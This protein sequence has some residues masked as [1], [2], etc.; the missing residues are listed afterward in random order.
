MDFPGNSHTSRIEQQEDPEETSGETKAASEAKQVKKV[1]TGKV[2]ENKPTLSKRFKKMF[3]HDGGNFAEDIA[4]RVVVPMIKDMALSIATQMVDG[5]R[6]GVEEMLFGPDGKERRGRTTSYG[7][8]DRRPRINYTQYSSTSTVRRS[9]E[10]IR[11]NRDDRA[12]R[13]NRVKEIIVETRED[14]EA[15][16]EELEAIIDSDIGHCTVGDFYAACGEST[17]STDEEWG[18]TNL[19]NA[20]VRQMDRYGNEFLIA[21]PEPRPIER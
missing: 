20:R 11:R 13:S 8:N 7:N 6:Q 19:Q 18:W 21:M 1:V 4:Q 14:G 9:A 12:R 15:V 2:T 17:V 5:F 3:L 10:P 16:L